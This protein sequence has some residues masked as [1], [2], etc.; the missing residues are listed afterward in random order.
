[1]NTP[2]RIYLDNAATSWP[3]PPAVYDAVDRYQRRVGAPA[4]RSSYRQAGEAAQLVE[5]TRGRLA[6]LIGVQEKER[7]VFT[8]NGTDSLNMALLG[9]LRPGDHVVTS[10]VEHNSVLRPLRHLEMAGVI[11]ITRVGCGKDGVIDP[12]QFAQA[13]RRDTR[14]FALVHASNV[15]GTIQPVQDVGRIAHQHGVVLLVD[16]AQSLGHLPIDVQ[17]LPCDLLASSGHKGLLGPLGT[18]ILY[19]APGIE[20]RISSF[21]LGGTGSQSADDQQ[22]LFLPDKYE[23]GNLNLPGIAGLAAGVESIQQRG[24]PSIRDHQQALTKR[25]LEGLRDI[26][27]ITIHGPAR[28]DRQVGVVSISVSGYDPQEVSAIL[29]VSQG[30]QVRSGLHCAPRMHQ[31]LGTDRLGGT[32]RFSFGQFNDAA[33]IDQAL[34][35]VGQLTYGS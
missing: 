17:Q 16:A 8:F 11:E 14:L 18:G 28:P 2:N 26:P 4:G 13:L 33:H 15:T 27:G 21:R 24:I 34:A 23:S 32:V 30:I 7:V 9:L 29:D 6:R 5:T 22:P 35:A 31:A 12:D 20:Q 19:L 3:K 1:M 10:V 25:M